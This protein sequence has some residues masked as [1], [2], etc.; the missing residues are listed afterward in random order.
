MTSYQLAITPHRRAAAR[1]IGKVRRALQKAY[2]D[3]PDIRQAD[4]ARTLGV[5]R[6][7]INRQLRGSQD[8]SLGRVAEIACV[9]GYYPE[10]ELAKPVQTYGDNIPP[11]TSGVTS[12]VFL[13]HGWIPSESLPEGW[14]LGKAVVL[15]EGTPGG[16]LPTGFITGPLSHDTHEVV[17]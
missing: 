14:A 4:I 3:S 17:L 7:V 6:A 13:A 11:S 8:M 5:N 10:F 12:H 1:F 2:A 16:T 15:T 9:L